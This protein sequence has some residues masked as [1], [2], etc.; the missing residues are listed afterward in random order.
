[1]NCPMCGA[2]MVYDKMLGGWWCDECRDGMD[3]P[4]PRREDR[5]PATI[6]EPD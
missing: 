6:R 3:G 1:M 2:A 5:E 4:E